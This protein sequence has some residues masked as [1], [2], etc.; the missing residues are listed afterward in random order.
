M[1]DFVPGKCTATNMYDD[2]CGEPCNPA[3]QTCNVCR[4]FDGAH[5]HMSEDQ[6]A[7]AEARG[8]DPLKDTSPSS[9]S[10]GSPDMEAAIA[11]NIEQEPPSP[12]YSPPGEELIVINDE[13]AV[14]AAHFEALEIR[15]TTKK[16]DP[17]PEIVK[18]VEMHPDRYLFRPIKPAPLT[19]PVAPLPP[20]PPS[21]VKQEPMPE[22][23]AWWSCAF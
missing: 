13:I 23:C 14:T 15:L 17:S 7:A 4:T 10:P 11:D 2:V 6:I 21:P 22:P 19:K 9:S 12:P 1:P 20:P 3:E 5:H 8:W 18:W 16:R